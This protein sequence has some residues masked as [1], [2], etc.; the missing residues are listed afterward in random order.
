[1]C[2]AHVLFNIADASELCALVCRDFDD[3][4]S[5]RV[6]LYCIRIHV[7]C[8]LRVDRVR[9][10]RWRR[11]SLKFPFLPVLHKTVIGAVPVTS[12]PVCRFVRVS[13]VLA[14]T[15]YL[16]CTYSIN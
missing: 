9:F 15:E 2:V 14:V 7:T 8:G 6:V 3:I 16:C 12:R 4:S 11:K 5:L 1:V 13:E 10:P